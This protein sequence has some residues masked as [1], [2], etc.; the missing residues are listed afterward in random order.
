M[1]DEAGGRILDKIKELGFD[2]DT[3]IIWTADHGDALGCH[4]GH[5]DKNCYMPE[6]V[7]RIPMAI[8]YPPVIPAGTAFTGKIDGRSLLELFGEKK[9]SWRKVV[10]G[11]K[12]GHLTPWMGR[13][14]ADQRWST[15][16]AM[17]PLQAD[18]RYSPL[19]QRGGCLCIYR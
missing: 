11:E 10:L 13:M 5:F 4:G 14:V 3:L 7:M 16:K 17:C 6:E 12:N 18:L 1:I 2:Q 9:S 8:K 15:W 19:P